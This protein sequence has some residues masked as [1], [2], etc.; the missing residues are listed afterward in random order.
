MTA[1]SLFNIASMTKPVTAVAALQLYEQGRLLLDDPVQKYFPAFANQKVA[2]L[3]ETRENIVGEAAPQRAITLQDLMRHTSGLI[4]GGRGTTP[5]HK[6][7]PAGSS[8]A[9]AELTGA[10][11]I[12]RVSAAPLLHQPG[13]VWDYGFGLDVLGL[14]IEQITG[15]T[16]GELDDEWR[17]T[18]QDATKARKGAS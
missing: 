18:L 3:D 2:I 1:D 5:V 10:E 8:A 15:K 16:Q 13:A 6:F 9:A 17:A 4:Y 14:V 11:F 7:Y 12:A